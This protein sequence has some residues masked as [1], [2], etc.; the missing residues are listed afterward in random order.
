M[1]PSPAGPDPICLSVEVKSVYGPLCSGTVGL[2]NGGT[3]T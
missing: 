2:S 3:V 1:G